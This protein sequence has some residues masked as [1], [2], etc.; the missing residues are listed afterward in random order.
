MI[1]RPLRELCSP[2]DYDK[3]LYPL[4]R[5]HGI[6]PEK[7]QHAHYGAVNSY[8]EWIWKLAADGMADS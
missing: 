6:Q 8:P 2:D 3:P 5:T 7:A 4:A 1:G